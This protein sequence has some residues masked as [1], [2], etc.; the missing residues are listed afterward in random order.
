MEKCRWA[1]ASPLEERY[2]DE[3]WGVPVHDDRL[4]FEFLILEGVQAGL[5]WRT[6]LAKREAYREAFA[7]FDASVI[8]AYD[9][10]EIER[11]LLNADL[12]RNRLKMKAAVANARS[13]LEVQRR[14]GSFDGYI[15]Q[16]VDGRPLQ[17]CWQ[18]VD[19]LPASS[20]QS[21]L[22]SRSLKG[23][24]FKFIGPTIC[25]AYM[26]AVGMVNDHVVT[27]FRHRQLAT[28]R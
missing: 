28:L 13:F 18:S 11:S 2:H 8:A 5:S 7:G 9:E 3:E 6:V 21:E 12:I 19:E 14:H 24:G 20:V 27:C 16:F 25:Y 1:L 26:Q 4:L 15:W 17:N 22:M 23:L 10:N